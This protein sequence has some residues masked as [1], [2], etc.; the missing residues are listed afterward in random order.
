MA[1]AS[2]TAFW[3][4]ACEPPSVFEVRVRRAEAAEALAALLLSL[5]SIATSGTIPPSLMIWVEL[6]FEIRASSASTAAEYA[7]APAVPV[8]SI[9]TSGRMQLDAE[10]PRMPSSVAARHARTAAASS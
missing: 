9:E 7:C 6:L 3:S 8:V 2:L 4:S 10:M 5:P 1:P